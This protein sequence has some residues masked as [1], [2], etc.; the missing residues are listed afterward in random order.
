MRNKFSQL[1]I[2]LSLL[3]PV[4]STSMGAN[5]MGQGTSFQE[6]HDCK[7]DT[8]PQTTQ[9]TMDIIPEIKIIQTFSK[10]HR[11]VSFKTSIC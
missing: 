6:P 7:A 3:L 5:C 4:N 11:S 10:Q 8:L 9:Q 1:I 2:S